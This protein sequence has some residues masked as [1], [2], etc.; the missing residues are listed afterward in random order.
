MKKRMLLFAVL[1]VMCVSSQGMAAFPVTEANSDIPYEFKGAIEIQDSPNSLLGNTVRIATLG[2]LGKPRINS[3]KKRLNAKL[4]E[5][6]KL[7][8]PDAV[9]N[10]VYSPAPED[11][12]FLTSKK[13]YAKGDMIAYKRAYNY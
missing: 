8:S 13:V 11:P 4:A 9:V 2:I 10:V 5:K 1:A 3:V 6:A 12:R 7:Y